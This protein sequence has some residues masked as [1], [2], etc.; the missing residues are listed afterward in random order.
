MS[1]KKPAKTKSV[2][3]GTRMPPDLRDRLAGFCAASGIAE[4]SVICSGVEQYLNGTSDA[5][6]LLRRLDRLGRALARLHRDQ[7][8]LSEAFAVFLRVWFAHTPAVVEEEKAA[9]RATAEA[10]YKQ[11]VEHVAARF[12]RGHRFLDDLPKELI[13]SDAELD[14]VLAGLDKPG[15][16]AFAGEHPPF[17]EREV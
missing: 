5:T 8:L 3:V 14:S 13:A 12:S 15:S 2:R 4:C 10:R 6:L 17:Q 11:F 16:E 9:A 1:M 7:Q